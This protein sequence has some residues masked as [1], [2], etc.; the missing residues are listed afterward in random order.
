MTIQVRLDDK[1]VGEVDRV[2]REHGMSRSGLVRMVLTQ[3][4]S[5]DI[6][7]VGGVGVDRFYGV[8]VADEVEKVSE[9]DDMPEEVRKLEE[10]GVVRRGYSKG[11]QVKWKKIKKEKLPF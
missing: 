4:V 6:G 1:L 8:S 5:G 9:G 2:A 10:S 11:D 7:L 3:V